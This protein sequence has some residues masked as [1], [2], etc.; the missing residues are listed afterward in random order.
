MLRRSEGNKKPSLLLL[1]QV[2]RNLDWLFGVFQDQVLESLFIPQTNTKISRLDVQRQVCSGRNRDAAGCS[3]EKNKLLLFWW[4]KS[5][6]CHQLNNKREA[7]LS[8][9]T[10]GGEQLERGDVLH[11]HNYNAK[12]KKAAEEQA[13][14]CNPSSWQEVDLAEIK[15]ALCSSC[16]FKKK[17]KALTFVHKA[18]TMNELLL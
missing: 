13:G 5:I 16:K 10:V 7:G 2:R 12:K 11:K 3:D 17:R 15:A 4:K 14:V 18:V 1:A 9:G 8:F 6:L